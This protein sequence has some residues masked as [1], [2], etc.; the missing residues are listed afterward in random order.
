MSAAPAP[1][2]SSTACGRSSRRC[3]ARRC[4]CRR[5]RISTSAAAPRR[6][7]YQYTLQDS[8]ID[9]LN[10]WAPKLL[11]AL[12]KLPMLRDVA[13]DQQT[14][15]GMLSL[16]IDRDQAARFGIQPAAV[17]QALYDAFGQ[18][19]AAQFFTQANS[20]HV[21][22]EITPS[23]QTDP[24]SLE[25]A[26]LEVAA[27]RADGAAVGH[28]QVR[29]AARH[30]PVDQSPGAVSGGDAVVQSGAGRG[31]G[32]CRRCHQPRIGR[33]CACRPPSPATSRAPRRPSRAR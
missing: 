14:S 4:S 26:V 25:Q 30:L 21:V 13:S 5:R 17:D 15:S 19:Q 18:R 1:I 24:A 9:E 23:L 16:T 10:N 7:Q 29:H 3:R 6:T 2:R 8:D 33:R 11:A 31:A 22:L 32:R 12:Q 28:D 20:Y 27:D